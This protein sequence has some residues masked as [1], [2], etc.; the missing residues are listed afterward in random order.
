MTHT[1]IHTCDISFIPE[2][3][4]VVPY[5]DREEHKYFF[6]NYMKTIMEDHKN[7]IIVF[8]HQADDKPF[9]RG[10]MKNMGFIFAK[11]HFPNNY[12]EI[13]LIFND[14][15]TIPYKKGLLNYKT[16]SGMVKHFYG[17]KQALGGIISLTGEDFENINGF[18]NYWGW[19]CE[20]NT[21]HDRCVKNGMYISRKQFFEIGN[22]NILHIFDGFEKIFSK[23]TPYK[24]KHDTGID[25]ITTLS[26][27][28][29]EVLEIEPNI[30][31]YNVNN[32]EIPYNNE[33][34]ITRDITNGNSLKVV[35]NIK[36][37]PNLKNETN[38]AI[39]PAINKFANNVHIANNVPL[40]NNVPVAN[41]VPLAN[42]VPVANDITKQNGIIRRKTG[43][44]YF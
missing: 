32:F 6:I 4:F 5:R 25:G 29:S 7:Y 3:I 37:E 40:A 27:I 18:P 26:N 22:H 23:Q 16:V 19:G 30:Y 35:N 21:L 24:S 31:M 15:D 8:C 14:I 17:F 13:T 12:K 20:D 2:Y 34:L 11:R 38:K 28:D 1:F 39:Q 36:P 33:D 9:N 42:N 43:L 41:N 10:A 44:R